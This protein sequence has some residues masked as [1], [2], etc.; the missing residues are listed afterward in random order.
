MKLYWDNIKEVGIGK[1][2]LIDVISK[3]IYV[4]SKTLT[5]NEREKFI[6]YGA[7]LSDDI[8]LIQRKLIML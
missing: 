6:I 8:L 1:F 7:D 5:E 4:S 2:K 3:A